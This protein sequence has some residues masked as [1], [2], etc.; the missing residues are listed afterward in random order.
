MPR[1]YQIDKDWVPPSRSPSPS[2]EDPK[3]GHGRE[4]RHEPDT[5]LKTK[6]PIQKA[7]NKKQPTNL[8]KKIQRIIIANTSTWI[9]CNKKLLDANSLSICINKASEIS[10]HCL[11]E[12]LQL[13]KK[14]LNIKKRN[15]KHCS[16]DKMVASKFL[17][18]ILEEQDED[19]IKFVAD[20]T[21]VLPDFKP[22]C[23]FDILK[24]LES[25]EDASN[26]TKSTLVVE[27][28]PTESIES[29]GDHSSLAGTSSPFP[30]S[31]CVLSHQA[32]R[33]IKT[34]P[35]TGDINVNTN[36]KTSLNFHKFRNKFSSSTKTSTN[37]TL[38]LASRFRGKSF[39]RPPKKVKICAFNIA[40]FGKTK[41][42]KDHILEVI[43][44]ILFRYDLI[45]VQEIRSE[46]F[47]VVNQT[48]EA[49]NTHCQKL[50]SVKRYRAER[51]N[52]VGN[53]HRQ[54]Q[55]G[56]FYNT[57][58][59]EL[60]EFRQFE[61]EHDVFMYE[62]AFA[63]FIIKR[64]GQ[65]FTIVGVH[66]QKDNV[67]K[68]LNSLINLYDMIT[69]EFGTDNVIFTGDFNA[70][71]SYLSKKKSNEVDFFNDSR[72]NTLTPDWVFEYLRNSG[73]C[74][75]MRLI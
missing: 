9:N 43:I 74:Q 11:Y 41:F 35:T 15:P 2:Q 56:Y 31:G 67:V 42:N 57:K 69:D 48:L 51:S 17:V 22:D 71:G 25:L 12:E 55:Y 44:K 33:K 10:S 58:V 1:S 28:N 62:P 18:E 21:R 27:E 72:F 49:L 34:D 61:D 46:E 52:F 39:K 7:K 20:N 37:S 30:S 53:E 4:R 68:E 75:N 6:N 65:E 66:I 16:I 45:V 24:R 40:N 63:N 26:Q 64:T 29:S 13:V 32:S 14:E 8:N 59:L 73:N 3:T 70:E 50:G 23:V 5:R 36:L 38:A 47:D 54:E 19:E 60:D